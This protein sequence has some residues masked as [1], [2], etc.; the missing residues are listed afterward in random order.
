[1]AWNKTRAMVID[2]KVNV[3][4]GIRAVTVTLWSLL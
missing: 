4:V 1:M 3:N 2:G